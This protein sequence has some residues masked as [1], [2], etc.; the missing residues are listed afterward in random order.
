MVFIANPAPIGVC[1]GAGIGGNLPEPP[2]RS[3]T[4]AAIHGR[5]AAAALSSGA[6]LA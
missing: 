3:P 5:A 4:A 6:A 2:T 1:G